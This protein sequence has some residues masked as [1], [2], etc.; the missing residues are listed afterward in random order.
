MKTQKNNS[1]KG[2]KVDEFFLITALISRRLAYPLAAL[3]CKLGLSANCVTIMSGISWIISAVAVV[4]SGWMLGLGNISN[5]Y[6]LLGISLFMVNLGYI[7][8]VADGS[9]ARMT[10][11]SSSSGYFLD[12]V[13]HLIFHPMY[14]CSIGIFLYLADG[15]IVYLVIGLISICSGWGASF[16]A[17]EH[18]LCEHIAKNSVDFT[19]F[20]SDERYQ[21]F[22]DSPIT[23]R[24]V[25]QKS[26]IKNMC[27]N[28]TKEMLLFPGQYTTFSIVILLDL[29]VMHFYDLHFV[30]LKIMFSTIAII[31]IARVPFRIRREYQT[32]QR[33]DTIKGGSA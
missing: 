22:M 6:W 31:T 30:L 12:Y 23:R 5:G 18:V 4:L 27:I 1:S 14:F 3:F 2:E 24:N 17:K 9:V 10:N 21:I 19:N 29:L 33:Y 15:G 26:G 28:L 25:K 16:S 7:L 20:S 32:L 13:F 8:D 11:T